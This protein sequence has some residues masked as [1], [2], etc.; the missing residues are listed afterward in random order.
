MAQWVLCQ[1]KRLTVLF[2]VLILSVGTAV[3]GE[4]MTVKVDK[5]N[6]RSEPSA[7]SQLLWQ[8]ERYHPIY[9][10]EKKGAWY[11]FKDFEG[12]QGWVHNTLLDKTPAVIV[13][14]KRCNVRKEPS[15]KSDVAFTVDRGIPFKVLE[16]K[17]DWF[18]VRHADG[19]EGWIFKSLLW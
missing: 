5:A 15:T 9:V 19:D 16:K 4:R 12:D 1:S 18:H 17:G 13:R 11:R 14:V 6:V 7:K 3:A 10:I 2:A 8:I